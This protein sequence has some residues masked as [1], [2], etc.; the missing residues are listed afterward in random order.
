MYL[1]LEKNSNKSVITTLLADNN[2]IVSNIIS[3]KGEFI[4]IKDLEICNIDIIEQIDTIIISGYKEIVLT[5]KLLSYILAGALN[6]KRILYL[7]PKGKPPL[8]LLYKLSKQTKSL[9][10][11]V[12]YNKKTIQDKIKLFLSNLNNYH[13]GKEEQKYTLRMNKNLYVA[14]KEKANIEKVPISKIIREILYKE[15]L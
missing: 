15:V 12:F 5:E 9:M 6:N 1:C 8:E 2:A 10:K 11:I 3:N 7:V 13:K 4:N 14:L